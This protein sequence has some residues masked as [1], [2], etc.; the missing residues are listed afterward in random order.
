MDREVAQSI[1]HA[2]LVEASRKAARIVKHVNPPADVAAERA[3][4]EGS[5]ADWMRFHGGEAFDRPWSADHLRVIDKLSTA[6]TVGGLFAYA[7]PR[8][9]GKTTILKWAT[10]Y[11]LLTGRRHYVVAVAATAELAQAIVDFCRQQITESDT[12]HAHYPHVTTY[13]RATDGKAIKARFQLR[14]DGKPSGITWSKTTLVLPEVLD[15][16]TGGKYESNG[17][18]LEGHGLTGAIRGKWKDSKSGRVIRPDFVL[19]DDPQSRESAESESQCRMRERIITGD[20]LGL[21][22]PRRRIAA[23]MPCTIIRK[24]DMAA[25]FLDHKLHP[26]WQGETCSLIVK[27]PDAQETLWQEYGQLYRDSIA[28]GKGIGPATEFYAGRR[29]EMDEGAVVAWEER[30][31]DG[32]ISALQTAQN[33]LIESGEQF[34]AEYQND[35]RDPTDNAPYILTPDTIMARTTKRAAWERPEWAT[36]VIASTDVNPSYALSTVVLGFGPDQT[37]A[38]LWYGLH[39]MSIPGETPAPEAARLLYAALVA[40]GKELAVAAVRPDF[41]AI[42]GGGANFDTVARFAGESIRAVGLAAHCF[43]GRGARNYRPYGKSVAGPLREG[44]HPCLDRKDGR[45]IRWVAWHSDH[46]RE[47]WQRAW[48]GDVGA[49]GAVSLPAG[50]H[51][52]FAQQVAAERLVGKGEVAGQPVWI[53]T[54]QPGR[55]DYGDAGAQGYAAAAY[56]GIGSGGAGAARKP[57]G[58]MRVA[59]Y[60]PSAGRRG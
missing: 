10:L 58:K 11:C 46:W 12:L 5:L 17:A 14:A 48:L 18:I 7:M 38:V 59:I 13:A 56:V 54:A 22:G 34:W 33:L 35:P 19:L 2:R 57:S 4:V 21:A 55:H 28:D 8:G 44:C 51:A 60:R 43:T 40:H 6:I 26:E 52:E 1:K 45:I 41:W 15:P 30:V 16:A 37:A 39:R 25:R 49:P 9:H 42:D 53:W 27:W 47:V 36:Q 31:R 50:H 29:A 32:E 24:G 20:V 3:R 23:V